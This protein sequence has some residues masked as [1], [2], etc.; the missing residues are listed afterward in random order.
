LVPLLQS[1]NTFTDGLL[2]TWFYYV[3]LCLTILHMTHECDGQTD[4]QAIHTHCPQWRQYYYFTTSR[5]RKLPEK[6]NIYYINCM[7]TWNRPNRVRLNDVA[8]IYSNVRCSTRKLSVSPWNTKL[9]W[10]TSF[11]LTLLLYRRWLSDVRGC[12]LRPSLPRRRC[13]LLKKC[14]AACHV[15]TIS[16]SL[17]IFPQLPEDTPLC[18]VISLTASTVLHVPDECQAT[19]SEIRKTIHSIK[20]QVRVCPRHCS[21]DSSMTY[22]PLDALLHHA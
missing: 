17:S 2:W 5:G 6:K 12:Q 22:W 18:R 8:H 1:I 10:A 9:P 16:L 4:G 14:T 19:L 13:W 7:V 20:V 21:I 11:N 15:G 3:M